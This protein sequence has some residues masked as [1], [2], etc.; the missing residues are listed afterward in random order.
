MEIN[1][2]VEFSTAIIRSL[3]RD[4]DSVTTQRWVCDQKALADVL[5]KALAPSY[6]LYLAPGQQNGAWMKGLD[7]E[8]Y[9]EEMRLIERCFSLDD[10]LVKGW[11]ADPATYPDEFKGKAIFLWKSKRLSGS[12][13]DVACL[14]W[15]GDR[16]VVGWDW[17]ELGWRGNDPALLARP[18]D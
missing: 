8:K 16:V 3:P 7:L 14:C 15:D 2:F 13:R 1:Q 5:R 11:I 9:L 10:E 18:N 12:R 6:E 17:L 4:L